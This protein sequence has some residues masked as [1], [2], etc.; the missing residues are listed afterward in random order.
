MNK[1]FSIIFLFFILNI[2]LSAQDIKILSSSTSS[3]VIEYHPVY[4]DTISRSIQGEKYLELVIAGTTVDNAEEFGLTQRLVKE[5]NVGV[6]TEFGSTIQIISSDYSLLEGKYVPNP[7]YVKDS[8]ALTP[9]YNISE[10]NGGADI[11]HELVSFGE[12]GLVRNLHVQSIKIRPVETDNVNNKIKVYNKI[13]F[14]INFGSATSAVETI[15]NDLLSGAVI[16]WDVAKKWGIKEEKKLSKVNSVFTVGDWYRFETPE[17]GIYKIDRSFLQNLGIDI[18]SIDPRTIQIYSNGGYTLPESTIANGSRK[19]QEVAINVIGES[20]GSFDANDYILFYGRSVEFWEYNSSTKKN[21][22]VK[23]PY[24]KKNYCWLTYGTT[25]GKRIADKPSVESQNIF[26]QPYTYSYITLD[27]DSVNVGKTGRDYYGDELNV[28]TKSRVYTNQLNGLVPGSIINYRFR[29]ANVSDP[30][31]GFKAEETNTLIYSTNI[32]GTADTDYI[33]GRSITAASVYNGILTD[34]RSNLKFSIITNASN[35]KLLIDFFEIEY[36][37]QLNAVNDNLLFLSKDTTAV[38]RYAAGGFSNGTLQA[39]DVTNFADVKL[40]SGSVISG[41]QINFQAN[42][43]S[44]NV[45]RYLAVSSAGFKTPS[46]GTKVEN[47][48]I[49]GN[50]SGTELIVITHKSLK[51]QVER[52]ANYRSNE[53]PY[54]VSTSIYYVDEILNEFSAGMMDPTAIRDFIKFAYENWLTKPNYVFLFGD[55][56]FDYLNTIKETTDK[57]LVPTYQTVESLNEL[58]SY[59][60]DDYYSRI[61]GNDLKADLAIGRLC[62][63]N[64]EEA[65]Y[66]VDKIIKYETGLERDMW[67]TTVTLVADDGPAAL[68]RDDESTHTAQSETISRIKIPS[69]FDQKKIYL[70]AYP[71]VISGLGRRKPAVNTAI[72]D[73]VNNGTLILNYIGHGNPGVW[74]HESVF[75]RASTIPQLKNEDY[76]FL[77]AAT[78]DFGKYDDPEEQSSTELMLNME[79]AGAVGAFTAARVVYASLNAAINELF[80]TNLFS[81]NG[82]SN[83]PVRIGKAYF[84]TKQV[85]SGTNDEKFHLFCDPTLRLAVPVLPVSIDSVNDQ[86]LQASVQINALGNVKIEGTVKNLDGT[87]SNYDGEAIVSVYDSDRQQYFAEM[88][89]TVTYPGGLIYRGR[90]NVTSGNFQTEFVVPKDIAYENKNGKISA[91][92]FNDESDGTGYT[93]NIVVGG[94]N[95]NAV[96]DGKGPEIEIFFDDETFENSYL[97]NPDFTLIAKLSDQTGLNTTGTG[98]GHKLE[99]I[100]NEDENSTIDLTNYFVGDLNSGGKSGSVKYKFT[101]LEPGDY[102]IK[103]KAWDVFN[104]FSSQETQFTVISPEAGLAVR[105]VYNYPNPF[106]SNTT[107][108]FQHNINGTINVRIKIY[109]IAGRLIKELGEHD[110]LDKF[111]RINWDGRDDDGNSIA[112]GTY[113]YKILVESSDGNYKD[114]VLGKIAVI[115]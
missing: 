93:N 35:A 69:Y 107:F 22:R 63:Q 60:M 56:D 91:Y 88:F 34:N 83:L 23:N 42:E 16:N 81:K 28:S 77:T 44:G 21:E 114:N 8:V 40:I 30:V 112:N 59:P 49:K 29:F 104:N 96:N 53:S 80:Y 64:E 15:E 25:T 48:N 101:S 55:G 6:P 82:E 31:M 43:I 14:S 113:L 1:K 74:A 39:F 27:K 100:L 24:S 52:F 108:T 111:V 57:N 89:Y 79:N 99:A 103:L 41:A 7:T 19:F 9:L 17:E 95:P 75:E 94:T 66:V 86:S 70:V 50:T 76:F 98:I 84:W 61:A 58:A 71:T 102:K 78:C 68:G 5:I 67:R 51:S 85:K 10:A 11:N 12:F 105:E 20:D 36:Q 47:S 92:I 65:K 54:K 45:S 106:S 73:A 13:V 33:F 4:L 87:K 18:S 46:N 37:R 109:T 32:Y 2:S 115:K 38:I 110:L 3:I 72:I 62:V 26:V 90:T 97:V